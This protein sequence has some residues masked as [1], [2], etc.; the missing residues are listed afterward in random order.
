[1]QVTEYTADGQC[2]MIWSFPDEAALELN[3]R[4]DRGYLDGAWPGMTYYVDL[5]GLDPVAVARPEQAVTLTGQTLSNLSNPCTLY[6]DGTAYPVNDTLVELDFTLPG[7]YRLRV[8]AFP[9]LDWL[10]EVTV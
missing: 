9:Y 8:E 1:M 4:E 5:S 2:G 10:G 3:R 7:T 6:I